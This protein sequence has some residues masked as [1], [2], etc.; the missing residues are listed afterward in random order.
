MMTLPTNGI[1]KKL[2]S[3]APRFKHLF[4]HSWKLF[5]PP[6]TYH[7]RLYVII[8]DGRN[9]VPADTTEVLAALALKKQQHAPFN[10][11]ENIIDHLVNNNVAA[12]LGTVWADKKMPTPTTSTPVDPAYVAQAISAVA[13]TPN[14]TSSLA[15]VMNY[16]K[17][18]A[19]EHDA[20]Y[21]SKDM[22]ILITLKPIKPF[23]ES[24]NAFFVSKETLV[25]ESPY[26]PMP[27]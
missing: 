9:A 27:L 15:S 13:N 6:Y 4:G 21:A 3:D 18:V 24:N 16:C 20:N 19:A 23:T 17:L 12:L 26:Q 5:T 10:Q 22:K 1:S 8:K 2:S 25:F 11:R 7:T 14:Y